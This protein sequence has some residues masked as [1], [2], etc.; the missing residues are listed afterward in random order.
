MESAGHPFFRNTS[1]ARR[2]QQRKD[3]LLIST[4]TECFMKLTSFVA[5]RRLIL[6]Y[7]HSC[8]NLM[9]SAADSLSSWLSSKTC[10][11]PGSSELFRLCQSLYHLSPHIWY[12]G[13]E[14]TAC[15]LWQIA[16]EWSRHTLQ[17]QI[18]QVRKSTITSG[19]HP[20]RSARPTQFH[21]QVW[22]HIERHRYIQL[23]CAACSD[24]SCRVIGCLKLWDVHS[25]RK[26]T[27]I[28][29]VPD[30]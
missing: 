22:G 20:A 13:C 14:E 1:H 15:W 11:R 3:S 18:G 21:M 10:F 5:P 2:L 6:I 8:P 27:L 9:V 17:N 16:N 25:T 29:Q 30:W 23:T 7:S 4:S 24:F 26:T 12:L 19:E 28:Y